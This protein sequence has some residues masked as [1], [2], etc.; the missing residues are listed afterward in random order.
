MGLDMGLYKAPRY[1][2]A[3]IKDV[4]AIESYFHWKRVK[5]EDSKYANCTLE[6]WCGVKWEDVPGKECRDFYSK[7]NVVRYPSWDKDKRY[8]SVGIVENV[9]Y[10]RK[11]NAIHK[12]FVD[13][14][15]D[16][17]DDC[18]YH[19]EVTKEILEDLLD[20]CEKVIANSKLI[21][22]KI[23]MKNK[24]ILTIDEEKVKYHLG[25]M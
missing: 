9:G 25:G 6:Q 3:T 17:I 19:N 2:D 13:N 24:E 11:A 4:F 22:G 15:Q 1:K 7:F 14:V 18:D 20:T 12:W 16:G 8:G 21:D 10:W 23:V 5:E